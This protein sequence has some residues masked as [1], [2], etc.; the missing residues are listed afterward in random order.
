MFP[1][2]HWCF[3]IK[4]SYTNPEKEMIGEA[5]RESVQEKDG[6]KRD[7]VSEMEREKDKGKKKMERRRKCSFSRQGR[8]KTKH[9]ATSLQLLSQNKMMT[10]LP[11]RSEHTKIIISN[12]SFHVR[13]F[14]D[15]NDSMVE[16]GSMSP[17]PPG[18]IRS[19]PAGSRYYYFLC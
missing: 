3:S 13:T 17:C 4:V 18:F 15:V 9:R 7:G 14:G 11:S 8:K 19:N 16:D 10:P 2:I 12:G 5:E 6:K 1:H